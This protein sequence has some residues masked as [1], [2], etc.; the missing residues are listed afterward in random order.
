[1]TPAPVIIPLRPTQAP[2]PK[3][4]ITGVPSPG[5]VRGWAALCLDIA[6][7]RLRE[8]ADDGHKEGST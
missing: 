5:A 1:M 7:K 3:W 2:V 8:R 4:T 6:R